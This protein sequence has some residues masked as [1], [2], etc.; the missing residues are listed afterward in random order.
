M[1]LLESEEDFFEK[2]YNYN[3]K[4]YIFM[5]YEDR[6]YFLKKFKGNIGKEIIKKRKIDSI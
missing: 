4:Y 3:K 5:S 6:I 2:Y 1:D